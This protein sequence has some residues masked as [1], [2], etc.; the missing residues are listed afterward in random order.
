MGA[1][2]DEID[3]FHDPMLAALEISASSVDGGWLGMMHCKGTEDYLPYATWCY[4]RGEQELDAIPYGVGNECYWLDA[5]AEDPNGYARPYERRTFA[6][7]Q[8]AVAQAGAVAWLASDIRGDVQVE[9]W[10][11]P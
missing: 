4:R 6:A 11:I 7:S 9:N 2:D 10:E 3:A 8:P 5:Y 1:D